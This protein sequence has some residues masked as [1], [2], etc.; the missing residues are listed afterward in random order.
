M[1]PGDLDGF[2]AAANKL[3][4]DAALR[5]SLGEN[6]RAYAERAYDIRK[7]TDRFERVFEAALRRASRRPVAPVM[8]PRASGERVD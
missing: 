5:R 8:T 4:G 7:T 3:A 2:I 1:H 6:G